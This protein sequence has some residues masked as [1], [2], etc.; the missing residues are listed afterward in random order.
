M[1]FHVTLPRF[2]LST[3]KLHSHTSKGQPRASKCTHREPLQL[4]LITNAPMM[5]DWGLTASVL[6][7]SER[8]LSFSFLFPCARAT[9]Q[10]YDKSLLFGYL[11]TCSLLKHAIV[12]KRFFPAMDNGFWL[13]RVRLPPFLIGQV[14][15]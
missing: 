10:I 14:G 12:L 1:A 2:Y 3:S 15:H 6:A 13:V 4:H 5:R 11:L 7:L 8:G 9:V